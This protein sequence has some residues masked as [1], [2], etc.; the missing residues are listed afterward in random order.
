ME[1]LRG[2]VFGRRL[3]PHARKHER[4]HAMRMQLEQFRKARGITLCSFNQQAFLLKPRVVGIGLRFGQRVR[5]P[6]SRVT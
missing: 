5:H 4:I 3:V 2:E 6:Q 1:H